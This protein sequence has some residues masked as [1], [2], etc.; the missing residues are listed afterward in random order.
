M[1]A[2][3]HLFVVRVAYFLDRV[4]FQDFINNLG[5]N[6]LAG[7][8]P[9]TIAATEQG[10]EREQTNLI[11]TILGQIKVWVAPPIQL[12]ASLLASHIKMEIDAPPSARTLTNNRKSLETRVN[13]DRPNQA[14]ERMEKPHRLL[15]TKEEWIMPKGITYSNYFNKKKFPKNV[16][17]WPIVK[18]HI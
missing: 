14:M 10:H 15:V 9:G 5:K 17:S 4:H 8:I 12:P 13:K 18:H 7:N 16:Q 6:P 3:G 11:H 2:A 1:Q